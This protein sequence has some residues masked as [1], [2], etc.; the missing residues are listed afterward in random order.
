MEQPITQK[1]DD[2]TYLKS[3]SHIPKSEQGQYL[4][5]NTSRM[6]AFS[7]CSSNVAYQAPYEL[8]SRLHSAYTLLC[9]GGGEFMAVRGTCREIVITLHTK[10][11][12]LRLIIAIWGSKTLG[13]ESPTIGL[14]A[15]LT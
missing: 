4:S 15:T 10:M 7:G 3:S 1:R 5:H 8:K 6:T 12:A 9:R 13:G 2:N 11:L 14:Y